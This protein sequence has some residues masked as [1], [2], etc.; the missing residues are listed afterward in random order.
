MVEVALESEESVGERLETDEVAGHNHRGRVVC[1]VAVKGGKKREEG[2]GKEL[3]RTGKEEFHRRVLR[4][5]HSVLRTL[6]RDG[7]KSAR[8]SGRRETG[9][10]GEKKTHVFGSR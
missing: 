8:V 5:V 9:K 4:V 6:L 1:A 10:K 3:R 7:R 2:R